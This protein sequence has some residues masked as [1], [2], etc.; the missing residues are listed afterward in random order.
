MYAIKA[1]SMILFPYSTQNRQLK[2]LTI[3]FLERIAKFL[4]SQSF[5]IYGS[6]D[7]RYK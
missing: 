7:V 5:H 3:V 2:I 1:V 4:T 6:S